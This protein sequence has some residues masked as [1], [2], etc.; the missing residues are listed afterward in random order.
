MSTNTPKQQWPGK[1]GKSYEYHVYKIGE[2][3]KDEA[4]NYIFCKINAAGKWE[5]QYI[6]QAK[7]LKDRIG[8]HNQEACAKRNGATHIHAHLNA[9]EVN[10]LAEEKDLI[11]NFKPVCNTQHAG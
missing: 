1:S 6:G 10:R 8:N 2:T 4:G 7:S 3:F 5:P 11:E 9:Q